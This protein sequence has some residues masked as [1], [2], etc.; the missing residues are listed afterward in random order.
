MVET[1]ERS[2]R[3]KVVGR[4]LRARGSRAASL[5]VGLGESI[6][7]EVVAAKRDLSSC[8]DPRKLE[9]GQL[10]ED[11]LLPALQAGWLR[12]KTEDRFWSFAQELSDEQL[13]D[14][15]SDVLKAHPWP[16]NFYVPDF[17][18]FVTGSQFLD[19]TFPPSARQVEAFA[20]SIGT[21]AW[22]WFVKKRTINLLCLCWG[23]GSGKDWLSACILAYVAFTVAQM[24]NPWFHFGVMS[25]TTL[26]CLNVA[27]NATQAK[28]VFY[29]YLAGMLQQECFAGLLDQRPKVGDIKAD[30]IVFWRAVP[31][32]RA[33]VKCLRVLS[34]NSQSE[35]VEGK[36]TFFW[37]MDE[38]DAFRTK[39]GHANARE[40]FTK[41]TTSNR[42]AD[43]QI[44]IVIS[45][46]RAKNG[47]VM[48]LL[49]EC[50]NRTDADGNPGKRKNA[51]GDKASTW[52]VLP[53]KVFIP[54]K[55]PMPDPLRPGRIIE[56]AYTNPDG[57][58]GDT[59]DTSMQSFWENDPEEFR[60]VYAC[61]PPAAE[62]AYI[63]VPEKIDEAVQAGL[64]ALLTPVMK[65][66]TYR[67][68]DRVGRHEYPYIAHRVLSLILRPGVTYYIGGDAGIKQDSFSLAMAHAVPAQEQ[69]SI[70]PLCWGDRT[71]RYAKHYLPEVV[72]PVMRRHADTFACDYCRTMPGE[73]H[74]FWGVSL[75][76]GKEIERPVIQGYTPA[77]DP[78]YQTEEV[79]DPATGTVTRRQVVEK[80]FLPLVVEDLLL[81]WQPDPRTGTVVDF[82]NV[83]EVLLQLCATGQVGMVQID[84]WQ[85]EEKIQRLR[86][87]GVMA[88]T[89]PMSNPAQ[90]KMYRNYKDLLYT[91]NLWLLPGFPKRTQQLK[92]L[93][94]VNG[95]K[96]DHP[97]ESEGGG[98]GAKDLTDAE[99]IAIQLASTFGVQRGT[100]SFGRRDGDAVMAAQ[101]R[102]ARAAK[103][104]RE[105]L[106]G[107]ELK[108]LLKGR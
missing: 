37:V 84:Q 107:A 16:P 5:R 63:S 56:Q 43:R 48:G 98:K 42:F 39:E 85:A 89:K 49:G 94:D 87:A 99:A 53:F 35:S 26:D 12:I 41:L 62:D 30:R 70:C 47:F 58:V 100:I 78:I 97:K 79:R 27:E 80:V 36:N 40:M 24:R 6:N 68:I 25:S 91:N 17:H 74:P 67:R 88:E 106:V 9:R 15:A 51:W 104:R 45:Y 32:R 3:V 33:R 90:L 95:M 13:R 10:L 61:D 8:G 14:W 75:P 64:D 34:L 76:S 86:R 18:E 60:R 102:S 69:G 31:G 73:S 59:P 71:K 11:I 1:G 105:S 28:D 46:P 81:E 21:S 101:G 4:L 82:E 22:D 54:C 72:L 55:V 93:Q 83:T 38:A 29:S 50:G 103:T 2:G 52:E 23:K 57:Y 66:E 20:Q 108:G 65:T 7:G 96:V 92:E 19:Q 44:G 77:G